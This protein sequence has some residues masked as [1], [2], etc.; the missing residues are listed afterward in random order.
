M[1]SFKR[2]RE[3][4]LQENIKNRQYTKIKIYLRFNLLLA[5]YVEFNKTRFILFFYSSNIKGAVTPCDI[6]YVLVE[7]VKIDPA[8]SE[9]R[10]QNKQT[11]K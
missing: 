1:I 10:I 9:I 7:T 8:V 4:L 11:D 3:R 2:L 6:S 5:A